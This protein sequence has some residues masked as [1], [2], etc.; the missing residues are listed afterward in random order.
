MSAIRAGVPVGAE[1][2]SVFEIEER[3]AVEIMRRELTGDIAKTTKAA[4][5]DTCNC[6]AR[7]YAE[8]ADGRYLA[9]CHHHYEVL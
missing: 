4:N 7:W 5:R 1:C 9:V 2:G 8:V 6:E 3:S